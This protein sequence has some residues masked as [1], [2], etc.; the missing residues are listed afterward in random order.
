MNGILAGAVAGFLATAPMTAVMS[1]LF[2][3]LPRGDR[4]PL[5]PRLVTERILGPYGLLDGM[6]EDR[7]TDTALAAH[8]GYGAATGALYPLAAQLLGGSTVITGTAY[9][10]AVWTASYLGW[11]PV[12]GTLTRA[13]RHSGR[14]NALMIAA[15]AVWGGSTAAIVEGLR[16]PAGFGA[17]GG[18]I[19]PIPPDAPEIPR[20]DPAPRAAARPG[21]ERRNAMLVLGAAAAI[22]G[23]LAWEASRSRR[24]RR[25]NRTERP[26]RGRGGSPTGYD[27]GVW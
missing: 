17:S 15:H 13:T 26:L 19:V 8:Y 6:D 2:P 4:Q 24:G 9:G 25:W 18:A 3:E 10:V 1:R 5:P 21:R 23:A 7:R 27:R 11:I 12:S 22:G 20:R 14:R 16:R